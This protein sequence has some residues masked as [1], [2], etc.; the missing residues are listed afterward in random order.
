MKISKTLYL[1]LALTIFAKPTVALSDEEPRGILAT[2]ECLK[3]V[4]QDR[5]AVTVSSTLVLQTPREASE[6][7]I[8]AHEKLKA[9][10]RALKLPDMEVD[11]ANY[12]V[13]QECSYNSKSERTC[14]GYRATLG[15]RFETSD[16]PSLGEIISVASQNGAQDVS[17][18]ATFVS[19]AKLKAER[20]GC[21]ETATQNAKAKALRLAAGA[22]VT[23]GKL[24]SLSERGDGGP[25]YPM[26]GR[27]FSALSSIPEASAGV[28]SIDA[29][30]TD[31]TVSVTSMYAIQ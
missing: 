17:D 27:A 24:L 3:K 5:G 30:P 26:Q 23:L 25:S 16:I 18:L 31:L 20:E 15:T 11:T 10:I 19:P 2:G 12:S 14:T 1:S 28:P 21:L 9:E 6:K 22:G 13:N 8:K 29:K 4:T 7:V